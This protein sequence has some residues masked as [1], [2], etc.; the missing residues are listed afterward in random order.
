MIGYVQ[1][2][3]L[4][5]SSSSRPSPYTHCGYAAR[6]FQ[7]V[8]LRQPLFARV[9][10][11]YWFSVCTSELVRSSSIAGVSSRPRLFYR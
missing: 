2:G 9:G 1:R 10:A 7:L 3:H 5:P 4:P 11:R 8:G 6:S